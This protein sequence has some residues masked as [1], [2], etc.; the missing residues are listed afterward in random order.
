MKQ[1]SALLTSMLAALLLLAVT[2]GLSLAQGPGSSA[3]TDREGPTNPDVV[4]PGAIPIQGRL[5]SA[6]GAPLNGTYTMTFRLYEVETGGVALCTDT[7][8]VPVQNGL[9]NSYIDYCYDG[10]LWGQKVWFSVQLQGDAEMTPRQVIY[11]VPYALGLVPGVVISASHANPFSVKTTAAS[12]RALEGLATS[13]TGTN[14]GV[15]GTSNSPDGYAGYF[16]NSGS[17][18][19]MSSISVAGT[20]IVAGSLGGP[21]IRTNSSTGTALALEGTGRLTSTAKSYIWISGNG[22][23]PWHHNDTTYIDMDTIGG[24]KVY[25]GATASARVVMLPI[26]VPGPL[27][28]QN[29]RVSALDVYWNADLD[30][31][32]ITAVLLRRQTG[33]CDTTACYDSILFDTVDH[34]CLTAT[35]CTLHY[36][37]TTDNTLTTSAGALYLAIEMMAG[38]N[39]SY[40]QIGGVR[41]TLEHD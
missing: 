23:R 8:S 7:N 40:I 22:V 25:P 12:G 9:F 24:A 21:T 18:I 36:A 28:G 16:Y 1:R 4:V 13:S 35:G 31:D 14:Y 3:E 34:T 20:A 39:D 26:T 41:L 32:A 33:V 11:P 5:T 10:T 15:Y 19:G 29:V 30:N 17:G 6:S 38:A 37:L 2:A 27:Y